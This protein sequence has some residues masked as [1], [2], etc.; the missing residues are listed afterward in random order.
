MPVVSRPAPG[1]PSVEQLSRMFP[2]H[3]PTSAIIGDSQTRYLHQHFDPYDR[4]APAFITIRGASTFDIEKELVNIP[5]SV[6]TLVFHVGTNELEKYGCDETLR[7]LRRLVN[8]TLRARPELHK[9]IVSSVLPRHTN[10]RFEQPN[11]RFVQW[12]NEEAHLLNETVEG[13]CHT[14]SK[15]KYLDHEFTS[16]PLRRFL[17]ADGLHP[18]FAGVALLAQNLKGILL[19]GDIQTAPGWSSRP[20]SSFPRTSPDVNPPA[21]AVRS[22]PRTYPKADPG[23]G[24]CPAATPRQQEETRSRSPVALMQ[25]PGRERPATSDEYPTIAESLTSRP[26]QQQMS[27]RKRH[28]NLR[29]PAVPSP[30]PKDD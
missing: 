8:N 14:P 5:R 27:T 19:R 17:A 6:T 23:P 3:L 13:Y 22:C 15:V 26:P 30:H 29:K 10:R 9:L 25:T 12:F 2:K 1:A 4:A 24:Q 20:A 28:Y 7:R 18:S 21:T 16:L 11:D